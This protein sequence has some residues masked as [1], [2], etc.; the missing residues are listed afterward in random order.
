MSESKRS[1]PL[2]VSQ[3]KQCQNSAGVATAKVRCS[4]QLQKTHPKKTKKGGSLQG[5]IDQLRSALIDKKLILSLFFSFFLFLGCCLFVFVGRVCV[6]AIFRQRQIFAAAKVNVQLQNLLE[7]SAA[8][9]TGKFRV[10]PSATSV[11]FVAA[12][13]PPVFTAAKVM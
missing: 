6:L 10:E 5:Q 12:E 11:H 7:I 1:R 3:A 9:A 2:S 8:K 13:L 4:L